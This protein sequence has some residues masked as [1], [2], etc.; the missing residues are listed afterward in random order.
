M[1]AILEG[2]SETATTELSS[3]VEAHPSAK[4]IHD[5][6]NPAGK[7]CPVALHGIMKLARKHA[8]DVFDRMP[9]RS[10]PLGWTEVVS[11]DESHGYLPVVDFMSLDGDLAFLGALVKNPFDPA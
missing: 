6:M 10:G 7:L 9:Q 3:A 11:F 1:V 4:S 2:D 5:F 8:R